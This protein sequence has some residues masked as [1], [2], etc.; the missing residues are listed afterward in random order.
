[1]NQVPGSIGRSPQSKG[2][3][4]LLFPQSLLLYDDDDDNGDNVDS[5][6]D[7]DDNNDSDDDEEDDYEDDDEEQS[8]EKDEGVLG[9][10][11]VRDDAFMMIKSCDFLGSKS[12][13]KC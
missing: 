5:D 10:C 7:D 4:P 3:C 11:Q 2:L 13:S 1:M 9:E 6:D 8:K 12:W